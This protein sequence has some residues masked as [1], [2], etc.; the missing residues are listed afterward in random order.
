MRLSSKLRPTTPQYIVMTALRN[1]DAP[2]SVGALGKTL[3][4]DSNTLTPLL[5]RMEAAGLL[6][7][8]RSDQD[9]RRVEVSL[10]AAGADLRDRAAHIPSCIERST[11]LTPE[12]LSALSHQLRTLD[13]SLRNASAL[14]DTPIS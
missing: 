11:G 3:H 7:R 13:A 10:T 12:A 14:S 1:E 9:E 4:L 6:A 8:R 2:M 5:K